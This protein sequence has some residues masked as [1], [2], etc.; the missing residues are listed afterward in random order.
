MLVKNYT[1][2]FY[3]AKGGS[4]NQVPSTGRMTAKEA[5]LLAED[6]RRN[7]SG[8]L[9]VGIY[10]GNELCSCFGLSDSMKPL[11]TI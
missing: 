4:C 7:N 9:Q 6:L 3:S 8:K 1:V 10:R 2:W 5:N 11:I